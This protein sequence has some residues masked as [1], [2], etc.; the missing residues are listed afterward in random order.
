MHLIWVPCKFLNVHRK[1][2]MRMLSRSWDSDWSFGWGLWTQIRGRGG[3]IG[4]R[5]W[6]RSKEHWW[7]PIGGF[8]IV[9]LSFRVR[10]IGNSTVYWTSSSGDSIGHSTSSCGTRGL[11]FSRVTDNSNSNSK[12]QLDEVWNSSY[13]PSRLHSNFCFIGSCMAVQSCSVGGLKSG[14]LQYL[15]SSYNIT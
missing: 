8:I 14:Y 1:L 11:D 4:G 5:R 3:R 12:T 7:L 13:R 10:V 9:K 15:V 6:Y 2:E